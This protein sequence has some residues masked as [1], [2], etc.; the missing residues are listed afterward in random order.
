[1]TRH[2][3]PIATEEETEHRRHCDPNN[4]ALTRRLR[5]FL[6]RI[7]LARLTPREHPI[8]DRERVPEVFPLAERARAASS[9]SSDDVGAR[10]AEVRALIRT[11]CQENPLWGAP[12]IHGELTK[13][14][15]TIAQPTVS[16]Y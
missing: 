15:I 11:M 3:Q 16:K 10:A 6:R 13:L 9:R 14:G 8:L 1:V 5:Y 7:Q 2:K 4:Q 12:R